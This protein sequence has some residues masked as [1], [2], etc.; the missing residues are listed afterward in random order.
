MPTTV[1]ADVDRSDWYTLT[2]FR[3]L[4]FLEEFLVRFSEKPRLFETIVQLYPS[5]DYLT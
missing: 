1:V 2:K 5:L 3:L 4:I